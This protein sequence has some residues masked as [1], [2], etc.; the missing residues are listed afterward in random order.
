MLDSCST[1]TFISEDAVK[2]LEVNG[3]DTKVMIRT[4]NGPKWHDTKVVNGLV[5]SDLDGANSITL[6]RVFSRDEIPG[7][8]SEIPRQELCRKWK[9]LERV[10]R[11]WKMLRLVFS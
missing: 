4:M 7:C 10:I 6:P 11:I 3:T 8:N 5:V 1:G 2:R 9:H